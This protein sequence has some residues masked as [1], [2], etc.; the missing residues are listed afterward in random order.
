MNQSS[1]FTANNLTDQPASLCTC[2]LR[3]ER[4]TTAGD[5]TERME[6]ICGASGGL[7]QGQVL[8]VVGEDLSSMVTTCN[9]CP[10]PAAL[11]SSRSCLNLTPVRRFPGGMRRLPVL[12]SQQIPMGNTEPA[13][14][15]FPCRWFYPLYGQQQPRDTIVCQSC[16]HWFPRPPIDCIPGYWAETHKMLRVVNGEISTDLP[17]TGFAPLVRHPPAGTWWQR[18]WQKIHRKA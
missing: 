16:P 6:Y 7:E 4:K 5:G 1:S 13:D 11:A 12:Q 14:A 15:Y 17:P 8:G 9:A 3:L 2:E 18:L 10:V